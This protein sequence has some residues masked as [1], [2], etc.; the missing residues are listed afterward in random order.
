VRV[1]PF[2]GV[3][4]DWLPCLPPAA[5]PAL[6][7]AFFAAAPPAAALD[8]LVPHAPPPDPTGTSS[9]ALAALARCLR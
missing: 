9:R 5:A 6:L 1:H 7:D 8:A 4:P 3:A 2:A